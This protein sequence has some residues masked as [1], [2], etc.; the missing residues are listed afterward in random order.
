MKRNFTVGR[1]AVVTKTVYQRLF[2]IKNSS[3]NMKKIS[4]EKE[5]CKAAMELFPRDNISR[6]RR[7]WVTYIVKTVTR[8]IKVNEPGLYKVRILMN[9]KLA[10]NCRFSGAFNRDFSK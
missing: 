3:S 1:N 8:S 10:R 4:G 5:S 9:K 6:N 7:N 2:G